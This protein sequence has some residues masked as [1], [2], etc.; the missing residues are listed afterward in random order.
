M[1]VY[2]HNLKDKSFSYTRKCGEKIILLKNIYTM[3]Y[4]IFLYTIINRK[5]QTWWD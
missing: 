1:E 3:V 5:Q 2:E 4:N